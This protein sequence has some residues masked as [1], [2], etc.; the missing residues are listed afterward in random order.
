MKKIGIIFWLAVCTVLLFW[1]GTWYLIPRLYEEPTGLGAGTFGDM[2]GAVNALFSGLAFVGLIYT[3]LVQREDLQEQKKA[4]KMQT[5]EMSLQVKALKM[6]A[7]ALKLQVEE[8]KS[9]K[10]EIARSADQLELQ[11]QLMDY[12][13]SLS[14]V[15]DLTKLKNSIVNNLRMNF[16]YS[17]FA[18]FKVIEKLSS[19]MEDEPNK[20]FDTEFKVLRRYS[21][22]YTLLIEFISKANFSEI[23]VND[24]KRIVMANTS[25]EE[26]NV[27]ER[28]AI[29]TSNQQLR[30]FIKDFAKYNM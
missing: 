27:L 20:P 14:T 5:Y 16:N 11:K 17:D 3:I 2:F 13:L 9:Q 18:G 15:N 6:Q 12:Q 22:T 1:F 24:L 8:M 23:Q 19:L 25:V 4:I 28:I 30:A 10:E 29:S 21:S 7:A 26:V